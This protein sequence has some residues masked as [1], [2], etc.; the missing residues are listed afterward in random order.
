MFCKKCGTPL[1]KGSI[2]CPNCG[3]KVESVEEDEAIILEETTEEE[4]KTVILEETTEEEDKTVILE[5][6]TEEEDRTVILE[7]TVEKVAVSQEK[8]EEVSDKTANLVEPV[9]VGEIQ[10]IKYCHNCGIANAENDTFCYSCGTPLDGTNEKKRDGKFN[11]KKAVKGIAAL[12]GIAVVV[13]CAFLFVGRVGK[14]STLIF[15]SNNEIM[16]V[17]GKESYVIGEEAYE[18]KSNA[19]GPYSS[20]YNLVQLSKDGRYIYYPQNY[21][22]GSF[23][24]YYKKLGK[25]D[26]EE[27]KI[28]SEISTFE[29]LK[30]GKV[31]YQEQGNSNRLYITDLKDKKKIASDVE[32]FMVSEDEKYVF[33]YT[34]GDEDKMYVCDIALK[35]DKIKLDTNVTEVVYISDDFQQIVYRKDDDLY[36]LSKFKN[37]QRIDSDV[38]NCF[39]SKK[40]DN[41]EV[42]YLKDEGEETYSYMEIVNDDL[43]EQDAAITEPNITDYQHVE[44]K[45]SFWGPREE[46]VTEDAYYIELEKYMQKVERDNIRESWKNHGYTVNYKTIFHYVPGEEDSQKLTEDAIGIYSNYWNSSAFLYRTLQEEDI[47]KFAFSKLM[48]MEIY[49]AEETLE[50]AYS[51]A[52]IFYVVS[53]EKEAEIQI[54]FKEYGNQTEMLG[55]SKDGEECY[56]SIHRSDTSETTLFKTSLGKMDGVAVLVTEELDEVEL[57]TDKGLYYMTEVEDG[58]GTLYLNDE[59]IASDVQI[60]SIRSMKSGEGVLY[61]TDADDR[62]NMGTLHM[63]CNQKSVEIGDDVTGY[64]SDEEGNVAFL[65]DYNFDKNR[66]DLM[67]Y[68]NGK[69][70][71]IEDDVTCILYY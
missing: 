44:T 51:D 59:E 4:D 60:N 69:V 15:L 18:S 32:W 3:S 61:L 20:W 42:Y 38:D 2:F 46:T 63:Y 55:T 11:I 17:K 27:T 65:V 6:T 29:V 12:A 10:K 58:V 45:Q 50:E 16:G 53:G 67:E 35:N 64:C 14:K 33:W 37:K 48:E 68:K 43:A 5:E 9:S 71:S 21:S 31:I 19:Y 25:E 36:N 7:E 23:D 1:E 8:Q 13:I 56:F 52:A 24:L 30:N 49:E 28:C 26:A 57:I 47:E 70:T 41:T 54:D 66:G 22:N 40:G 62:N 39:V 34:S